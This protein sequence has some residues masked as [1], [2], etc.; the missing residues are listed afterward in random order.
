M[1]ATDGNNEFASAT[2]AADRGEECDWLRRVQAGDR[3]VF[4]KLVSRYMQ[5]AYYG[6]LGL[7]GSHADALDLS[8]EAFVRAF[9]AR[10]TLDPER[11]FYTWYYQ[12]LRRLCFNQ[13]RD[14]RNRQRLHIE[15]ESWLVSE[16]YSRGAFPPEQQ[17]ETDEL[18]QRI[19]RAIEALPDTERE[20]IVMRELEELSYREIA[21]LLEIPQGTVMS[22]LYTARKRL[23]TELLELK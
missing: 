16:A 1:V 21:E 17:S 12:I 6:A 8:Q 20:I 10:A 22:R 14:Q 2:P 9:R 7:V 19:R 4:G 18:Y 5:R 15:A 13:G 3:E 23:A 11:P